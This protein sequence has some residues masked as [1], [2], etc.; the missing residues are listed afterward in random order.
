MWR[1]STLYSYKECCNIIPGLKYKQNNSAVLAKGNINQISKD[2]IWFLTCSSFVYKC[3]G[4]CNKSAV[5]TVLNTQYMSAANLIIN[6]GK[7][8]QKSVS[9]SRWKHPARTLW[10]RLKGMKGN[11]MTANELSWHQKATSRHLCKL[12]IKAYCRDVW[13]FLSCPLPLQI[14]ASQF[15]NPQKGLKLDCFTP[16]EHICGANI[17]FLTLLWNP[18]PSRT[19]VAV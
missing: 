9:V 17:S 12:W 15:S 11:I 4:N 10:Q 16:R 7:L 5:S 18:A 13:V 8:G 2:C 1:M 6:W 14:E 3:G 19:S